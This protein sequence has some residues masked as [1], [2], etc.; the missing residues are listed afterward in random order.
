MKIIKIIIMNLL[1]FFSLGGFIFRRITD[2]E[3]LILICT[4]AILVFMPDERQ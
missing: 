4:L 3:F 1:A 2:I